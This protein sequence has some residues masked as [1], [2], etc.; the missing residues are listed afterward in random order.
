MNKRKFSSSRGGRCECIC[1][2]RTNTNEYCGY[3]SG[4]HANRRPRS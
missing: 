3:C 1:H 2:K 4:S